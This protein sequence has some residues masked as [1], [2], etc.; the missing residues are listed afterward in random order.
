MSGRAAIRERLDQEQVYNTALWGVL[1]GIVGARIVHVLDNW[2]IY[3]DDPLSIFAVWNGGI[4]LWGGILGGWIAGLIYAYFAKAPIGRFMDIAAAPLLVAQTIGRI[5]DIING[6]HWS[7]PLDMF[8]GWYFT[9]IDSPARAVIDQYP[10]IFGTD[11]DR[12]VHPAVV[13]EM[14]TNIIILGV[15]FLLRGRVRPAGSIFMIYLALYATAR[16]GIQFVRLDDVKFWGLQEAHLIAILVWIVTI[17]WIIWKVRFIGGGGAPR[18]RIRDVV[19]VD[20]VTTGR[21][22]RERRRELAR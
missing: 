8:W 2:S 9:D 10:E 12:P 4:G 5:G 21:S 14:I 6:E 20:H 17:P 3:G 22:K 16:F 1:G 13:Y 7:R 15:I 19:D 11:V 18:R